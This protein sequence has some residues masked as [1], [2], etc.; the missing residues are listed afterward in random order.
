ECY[1]H[2]T[3]FNETNF[4]GEEDSIPNATFLAPAYG[5]YDLI[6]TESNGICSNLKK[7]NAVFIR[8]PNAM[9]GSE[10]N[11]TDMVCQTDGSSDYELMA[12]PLNSGETGTWTSPEGTTFNDPGGINNAISNITAPSEIGTYEFTWTFC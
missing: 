11:A 2:G 8:P 1:W 6:F 5:S 3:G 9:A 10:E 12:S 4:L 7:V